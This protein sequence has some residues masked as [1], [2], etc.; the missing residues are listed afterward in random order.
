MSTHHPIDPATAA[1]ASSA[2]S[3]LGS[4]SRSAARSA[5]PAGTT[6]R[7]RHTVLAARDRPIVDSTVRLGAVTSATLKALHAPDLHSG[8]FRKR[9]RSLQASGHVRQTRHVGPG[10]VIWLYRAGPAALVPNQ[11]RPWCPSLAQLG[12]TLAIGD[13]L[14]A[15]LRPT[16]TDGIEVIDWQGEAE[17]R[18]WERPGYPRPDLLITWRATPAAAN[19]RPNSAPRPDL[20]ALP[21]S[22]RGAP[23]GALPG[24]PLAEAV[25]VPTTLRH[26]TG[27]L[28][29]EVDQGTEAGG[30]WRRKLARYL[31]FQPTA[32]ILVVTTSDTRARNI[33]RMARE[34]GSVV[35]ATTHIGIAH[36]N[37]LVYDT[38]SGR[39]L[40]FGRALLARAS[41][42]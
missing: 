36:G 33:A 20:S 3:A 26:L 40:P 17:L 19:A 12:H 22:A 25:T 35:L 31:T 9:L 4:G 21:L 23:P 41:P 13:T 11:P 30:A 34:T 1:S 18:A 2:V 42:R 37:T 6:R 7:A 10:H 28:S 27:Q 32:Q 15:L 29:V 8:S 39:R 14:I 38:V 16:V 24:A 5:G